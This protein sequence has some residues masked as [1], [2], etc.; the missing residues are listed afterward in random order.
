MIPRYE[1]VWG[2]RTNSLE[3]WRQHGAMDYLTN[4]T[5]PLFLTINCSEAPD[6]LHQM[7]VL[8]KR[9]AE[10]GSDE[11]F[12]MDREPRGHKVTL[13]PEILDAMNLYLKQRLN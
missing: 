4:A 7:T 12:L 9:L 8:R 11:I 5:L 3:V 13:D 6:A 1:E 10:L 2:A